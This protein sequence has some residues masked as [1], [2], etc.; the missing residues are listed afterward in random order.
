MVLFKK[1]LEDFPQ[2][3]MSATIH[4][5]YTW[6]LSPKAPSS[7]VAPVQVSS[8]IPPPAWAA[9]G[10]W[11]GRHWAERGDCLLSS[12][13]WDFPTTSATSSSLAPVL[14]C[15]ASHNLDTHTGQRCA[16]TSTE[17]DQRFCRKS[18]YT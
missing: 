18:C 2:L 7:R 5:T 11:C 13:N 10:R 17:A 14:R 1:R 6:R 16:R 12:R 3:P 9:W 8:T 4:Y 15:G